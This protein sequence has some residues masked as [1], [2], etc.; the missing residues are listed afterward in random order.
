[1][2]TAESMT[3]NCKCE[4]LPECGYVEWIFCTVDAEI[5]I[6]ISEDFSCFGVLGFP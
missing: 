4:S 2:T 1:M 5:S 3:V 6:A